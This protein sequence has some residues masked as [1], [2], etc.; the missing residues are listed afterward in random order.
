MFPVAPVSPGRPV[1]FGV[2][3]VGVVGIIISGICTSGQCTISSAESETAEYTEVFK[4]LK[5]YVLI[6][7]SG[8]DLQKNPNIF[9]GLSQVCHKIFL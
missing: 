8:S 6:S 2:V 7:Y 9:L 1:G 4:L 5:F 3:V